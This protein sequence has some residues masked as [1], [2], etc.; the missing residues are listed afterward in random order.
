MQEDNIQYITSIDVQRVYAAVPH[1]L[2]TVSGEP[3]YADSELDGSLGE[4]I[5]GLPITAC[6]R[7]QSVYSH[8]LAVIH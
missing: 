4:R 7:I 2:A 8:S 6:A 5:R 3:S 1:C